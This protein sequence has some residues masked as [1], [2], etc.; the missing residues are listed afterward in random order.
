[1]NIILYTEEIY[2]RCKKKNENENKNNIKNED[3]NNN[4]KSLNKLKSTSSI[5]FS[6]N[7]SI[8]SKNNN[9]INSIII[10]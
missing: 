2:L 6:E 7:I 5:N 10:D 8:V 4:N 9:K 1:M 3:N